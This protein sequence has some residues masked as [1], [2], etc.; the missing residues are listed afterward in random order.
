LVSFSVSIARLISSFY[1][2]APTRQ[3]SDGARNIAFS[4]C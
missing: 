3:A 2:T 4:V 1:P